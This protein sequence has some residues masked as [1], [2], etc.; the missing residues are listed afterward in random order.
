M[1]VGL[2]LLLASLVCPL[3]WL[4]DSLFLCLLYLMSQRNRQASFS[5]MLLPML[6]IPAP[7]VPYLLLAMDLSYEKV[8]GL[9]IGHTYFF[10]EDVYPK[11]P[12]SAG[13]RLFRTPKL[14][15]FPHRERLLGRLFT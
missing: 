1:L 11:L 8:L 5:L 3:H 15:Y 2:T 12:R 14:V 9:L 13:T 7:Y 10:F 4:S 6:K